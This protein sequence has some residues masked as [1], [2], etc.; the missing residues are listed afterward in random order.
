[1]PESFVPRETISKIADDLDQPSIN[2]LILLDRVHFIANDS[3][4]DRKIGKTID[5]L[6]ANDCITPMREG[7]LIRQWILSG[8]GKLVLKE[9]HDRKQRSED[10]PPDVSATWIPR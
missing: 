8:T 2:L 10:N 1:M 3:E 9:L 6:I 4:L 7:S 5:L